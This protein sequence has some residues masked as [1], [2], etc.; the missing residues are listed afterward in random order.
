MLRR[1]HLLG[2]RRHA[3][4]ARLP[5]RGPRLSALWPVAA[6]R[7]HDSLQTS[8]HLLAFFATVAAPSRRGPKRRQGGALQGGALT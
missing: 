1:K 8:N 3:T 7:D 6:R 5:R 4:P 2:V